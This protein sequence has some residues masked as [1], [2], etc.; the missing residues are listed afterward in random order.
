MHLL[1]LRSLFVSAVSA[2]LA[3][4]PKPYPATYT[5]AEGGGAVTLR[6]DDDNRAALVLRPAG[7]AAQTA[8]GTYTIVRDSLFVTVRNSGVPLSVRGE[9]TGDDLMLAIPGARPATFTRD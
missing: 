8:E 3:C 7:G 6:L 2:S 4:A 1:Q 5:R 9:F